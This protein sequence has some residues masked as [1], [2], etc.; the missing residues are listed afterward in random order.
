MMVD[1]NCSIP[2]CMQVFFFFFILS[3]KSSS[4]LESIPVTPFVLN[5]S[6][7]AQMTKYIS[8]VQY[9]VEQHSSRWQTVD[10]ND[11][12]STPQNQSEESEQARHQP[13]NHHQPFRGRMCPYSSGASFWEVSCSP[14]L[15]MS[16]KFSQQHKP[17]KYAVNSVPFTDCN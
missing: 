3:E 13:A 4:A 6:H 8:S 15:I 14:L 1:I 5:K 12:I 2:T 9:N 16:L 10:T 17:P 7:F 11:S